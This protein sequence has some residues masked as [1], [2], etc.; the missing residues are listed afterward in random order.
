[1]AGGG[2]TVGAAFPSGHRVLWIPRAVASLAVMG[3][4]F[5]Y[6]TL[7]I[8]CSESAPNVALAP[9]V[10]TASCWARSNFLAA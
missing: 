10:P 1:V 7:S 9:S 3:V 2:T 4:T 6:L 8:A 5:P